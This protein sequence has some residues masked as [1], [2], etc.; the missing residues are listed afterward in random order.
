MVRVRLV[1]REQAAW[2]ESKIQKKLIEYA[3]TLNVKLIPVAARG[4]RGFPDLLGFVRAKGRTRGFL[5]EIKKVNG[6]LSPVQSVFHR[7]LLPFIEVIT[8]YGYLE[9][10]R[11][12]YR[13]YKD[14]Q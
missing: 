3:A 9:A 13:I 1:E 14:A 6:R 7:E 5:I 8:V 11:V 2:L 12:V 10:V 4:R